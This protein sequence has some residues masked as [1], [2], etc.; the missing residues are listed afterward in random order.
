MTSLQTG[1]K[2]YII[3]INFEPK[4]SFIK[5]YAYEPLDDAHIDQ[6]PTLFDSLVL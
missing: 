1:H 2:M 3:K 6:R 4:I 5:Q